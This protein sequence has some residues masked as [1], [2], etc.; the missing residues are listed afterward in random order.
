MIIDTKGKLCPEPLI[1]TRRELKNAK[2]G[3]R[4]QII[5]DNDIACSNLE[6]F[7]SDMG[8]QTT[9][10]TEGSAKVIEFTYNNFSVAK[11]TVSDNCN[12][13]TLSNTISA[14]Y[15]VVI[16]SN[17]MGSGDAE[18][19]ELLL[20]AYINTLKEAT[21]L[22]TNIILYNSG[23]K[24]ALDGTDTA[25]A[26]KELSALG[27]KVMVCGTCVSYY[28]LEPTNMVGTIGNMFNI[29]EITSQALR[30]VY[31]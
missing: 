7:L 27:V 6:S 9:I 18:L 2:P 14:G 5:T 23:V 13:S 8:A 15:V 25:E 10:K 29:A 30:V 3:E 22:P 26:L 11:P 1:I 24:V 16:K 31:P 20:R 12:I 21:T 28:K 4:V 17:C 19:G